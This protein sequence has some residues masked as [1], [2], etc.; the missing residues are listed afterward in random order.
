MFAEHP[1]TKYQYI[2]WFCRTLCTS[3]APMLADTPS[4]KFHVMTRWVIQAI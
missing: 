2:Y 3:L 1:R 4:A